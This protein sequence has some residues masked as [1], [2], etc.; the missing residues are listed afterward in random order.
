MEEGK[1]AGEGGEVAG[2]GA[3]CGVEPGKALGAVRVV[4][5]PAREVGGGVAGA[6]AEVGLER[7][8]PGVD[9]DVAGMAGGDG[10]G[11][12]VAAEAAAGVGGDALDL[13]D[14]A[15]ERAGVEIDVANAG[16]GERAGGRFPGVGAGRPAG[17]GPHAEP[18]VAAKG[19][20]GMRHGLG[21]RPEPL[22]FPQDGKGIDGGTVG[23]GGFQGGDA[24]ENGLETRAVRGGCLAEEGGGE[25]P[26]R[27]AVATRGESR[28]QRLGRG[29]P[30]GGGEFGGEGEQQTPGVGGGGVVVEHPGEPESGGAPE[31]GRR[32]GR[33]CP[34]AVPAGEDTHSGARRGLEFENGGGALR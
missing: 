3:D 22:L 33:G 28:R 20:E 19:T 23:G 25:P 11:E 31:H 13:G 17:F 9:A 32:S 24:V 18:G 2:V 7:K 6:F 16:R 29:F 1:G 30:R 27:G 34:G 10:V 12:G 26:R 8:H 4:E 14:G 21:P 15:G 5:E